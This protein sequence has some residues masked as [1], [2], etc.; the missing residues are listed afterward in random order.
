MLGH[1]L[2][3]GCGGGQTGDSG[4]GGG[5]AVCEVRERRTVPLDDPEARGFP[6]G[7]QVLQAF[8]GAASARIE[9]LLVAPPI[10]WL[11]Q[12]VEPPR[13]RSVP[14]VVTLTPDG[15]AEVLDWEPTEA[16]RSF[17]CPDTAAPTVHV[18]VDI[19]EL[20]VTLAGQG[21]L[22]PVRQGDI[23]GQVSGQIVEVSVDISP[24]GSCEVVLVD[25]DHRLSRDLTCGLAVYGIS[26]C[27]DREPRHPLPVDERSGLDA[28]AFFARGLP[29]FPL[30]LGCEGSV[31]HATL[32]VAV[33]FPDSYCGEETF[34]P[35]IV[36]PALPALDLITPLPGYVWSSRDPTC[37][38]PVPSRCK[39][40]A[41]RGLREC[42]ESSPPEPPGD[43]R[44][45]APCS[46]FRV[47]FTDATHEVS[48]TVEEAVDGTLLVDALARSFT[49]SKDIDRPDITCVGQQLLAP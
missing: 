5:E 22:T 2:L 8:G 9:L 14:A 6:V 30:E 19:A 11:D 25:A 23:V 3:G 49:R 28:R 37:E 46:D 27:F 39:G 16:G 35:V 15:G 20:G 43:Q 17:E 47:T 38:R 41:G 34:V 45:A 1:T 42:L 7:A 32:D 31:R 29:A 24:L 10:L 40:R 44:H 21:S 48:I 36:E 26:Q 18:E 33:S 4:L 13:D 12:G